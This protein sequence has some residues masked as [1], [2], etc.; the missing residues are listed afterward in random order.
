MRAPHAAWL[1]MIRGVCDGFLSSHGVEHHTRDQWNVSEGED[2]AR[3]RAAL[4]SCH[5]GQ[6]AL[7]RQSQPIEVGPP[8]DRHHEEGTGE[9]G[10]SLNSALAARCGES[11]GHDDFAE[12]DDDE[13]GV[14]LREMCRFDAEVAAPGEERSTDLYCHADGL[15]SHAGFALED[16]T[17]EDGQDTDDRWDGVAIP[18]GPLVGRCADCEH[19]E[20][21]KENRRVPDGEPH[22]ALTQSIG[23]CEC[24]EN[25]AAMAASKVSFITVASFPREF[26][27]H[28]YCDHDHQMRSKTSNP[29]I[30]PSSDVSPASS[31][32][33]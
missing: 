9:C 5:G 16:A 27:T 32:A 29:P 17:H 19:S 31:A 11:D 24:H 22:A 3:C 2:V 7:H 20:P 14:A 30:R 18:V 8:E 4:W 15:D 28:V 25:T 1:E 23:V 6:G 26:K 33:T 13:E 21:E 10:R 12:R